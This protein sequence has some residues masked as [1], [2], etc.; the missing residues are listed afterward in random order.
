MTYDTKENDFRAASSDEE[1]LSSKNTEPSLRVFVVGSNIITNERGK[2][3]VSF[4]ISVGQSKEVSREITELWKIEKLYSDF[5]ALDAQLRGQGRGRNGKIG[6]LPEKGLFTT[7]APSK[8][9]KRKSTELRLFLNSNIVSIDK[10]TAQLPGCKQGYLTKRGKNFGGWKTRYF[11]L[12]GSELRYF[13]NNGGPLLGIIHVADILVESQSSKLSIDT[14]DYNMFRHCFVLL[15]RRKTSSNGVHR[16]ILCAESDTERDEWLKALSQ[17]ENYSHTYNA[18]CDTNVIANTQHLPRR[19]EQIYVQRDGVD[20][21]GP[22]VKEP[23]IEPENNHHKSFVGSEQTYSAAHRP[24]RSNSDMSFVLGELA[25]TNLLSTHSHNSFGNTVV[26]NP[27]LLQ[28]SSLDQANIHC[29][30]NAHYQDYA[31]IRQTSTE[32][33][34]GPGTYTSQRKT[35]TEQYCY[36]ID[37]KKIKQ[38]TNRRTFWAKKIFAS[39]TDTQAKSGTSAPSSTPLINGQIAFR[40][41]L[42]RN[43]PEATEGSNGELVLKQVGRH[44]SKIPLENTSK[45][46]FGVPLLNAV[47][48]SKV[49]NTYRLPLIVYRCIDYLET[50]KAIYEEGIYRLSGSAVK[51]KALRSR[52]NEKGDIDFIGLNEFHD[53]HGIAG[54]LKLWLRELPCHVFTD[55]LLPKFMSVIDLVDRAERVNELQRLVS[56]LPIENYTLLRALTAHLIRVVQNSDVNRMTLHNIGIVF[57]P[58]LKIPVGIFFLFIYEFDAIFSTSKSTKPDIEATSNLPQ[59]LSIMNPT[60]NNSFDFPVSKSDPIIKSQD[61]SFTCEEHKLLHR[62]SMAYMDS[63]P[64]SI[65]GLEEHTDVS[66]SIGDGEEEEDGDLCIRNEYED[67]SDT[68]EDEYH[69]PISAFAK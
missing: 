34:F 36:D 57:S 8:V 24:F 56:I 48:I 3:L 59:Y 51:I 17:N 2:K 9:D 50:Q 63:A 28:R 68:D 60:Q 42:S 13:E 55:E 6:K 38:K 15:E 31:S 44:Q 18:E 67:Y 39:S 33:F 54:L 21:I 23:M 5:L 22:D 41:F 20:F 49:S 26:G 66:V 62:N 14:S 27:I 52:F 53:I 64:S 61:N 1:T 29:K 47:E 69:T 12:N 19:S 30:D 37:G 35:S 46:V 45:Q 11:I 25:Q 10:Q 4:I 7:H 43:V 65:M 32:S 16:H 40:A 58:T